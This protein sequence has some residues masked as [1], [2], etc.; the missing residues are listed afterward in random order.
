MKSNE[1]VWIINSGASRHITGFKDKF[2]TF[3]NYL[4]EGV[5][6]GNNSTYPVKGIGTCSIQLRTGVTLK[7]K[8]VLFVLGIKRNLVSIYELVDE[9]FQVT[10]NEDKVLYWPKYS[11]L[12][13]AIIIGSRDGTLYKLCNIQK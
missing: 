7:L 1:N 5:T 6:I 10:F 4:T 3:G 12:K 11:N 8:D 9:G 2:E 13:N